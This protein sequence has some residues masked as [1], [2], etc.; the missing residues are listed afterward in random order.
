MRDW[1]LRAL[2]RLL[3]R[4][5]P[6]EGWAV[7]LSLAVI[8]LAMSGAVQD[9]QWLGEAFHGY[10]AALLGLWAGFWL[11]RKVSRGWLA[12]GIA[13]AFGVMLGI[14]AAATQFQLPS[15]WVGFVAQLRHFILS[16]ISSFA[17]WGEA[18]LAPLPLTFLD[19]VGFFLIF[20]ASVWAGWWG[21]RRSDAWRAMLMPGFLLTWTV[22]FSHAGY[23]WVGAFIFAFIILTISLNLA[24]QRQ[25]WEAQHIDYSPEIGLDIFLNGVLIALGVSL[26][27]MMTPNVAV[28][29]ITNAFWRVWAEPYA[30]LESQISPLFGELERPPR[31]LIGGGSARP[32]GLPRAHLLGG[33]PELTE[34]VIM[35]VATGVSI[36]GRETLLALRGGRADSNGYSESRFLVGP[37]QSYWHDG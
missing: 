33:R 31:S 34:Q 12:S 5:R 15:D 16:V 32:S 21:F 19:A 2:G 27:A 24:Q 10:V 30:L 26:L 28:T 8:V 17:V 18:G 9:A 7:L 6:E 13:A 22:F 4:L 1:V 36:P 25:D 29:P 20:I 3:R 11:A 14:L 35:T 23:F 37:R